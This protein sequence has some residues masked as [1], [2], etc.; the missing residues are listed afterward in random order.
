MSKIDAARRRD[1]TM[2]SMLLDPLTGNIFD[3]FGGVDDINHRILR[4]TDSQSF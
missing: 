1:F 2:N 4:V 3:P